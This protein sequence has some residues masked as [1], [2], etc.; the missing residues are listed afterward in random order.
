MGKFKFRHRAEVSQGS[1]ARAVLV[2]GLGRF[3]EAVARGL[4]EQGI[5]VLALDS[6]PD[7]VARLSVD[8]PNV[9]QAD[10]T[11]ALA[12][13]QAGAEQFSHA[14]VAIAT[15]VEASVLA[16]VALLDELGI[17]HVW[18]KAL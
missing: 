10:A 11:S 7:I 2:A 4:V 8:L 13:R 15:N 17:E 12:L 3:G 16:A 18:A 14:V 9:V 1:P 5:E 6:D